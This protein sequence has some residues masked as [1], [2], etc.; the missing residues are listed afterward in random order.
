MLKK[1]LCLALS[2]LIATSANAQVVI[3]NASIG[4]MTVKSGI[5]NNTALVQEMLKYPG[6]TFVEDFS[7]GTIDADFSAGSPTGT[8]KST[9]SATA[10]A[11]YID[12]NGVIQVSTTSDVPLYD[13]GYYDATG[14][15]ATPMGYHAYRASTNLSEDSYT[16]GTLETY[17]AK[18]EGTDGTATIESSTERTN[19]YL[20]GQV[21]KFKGTITND[22]MYSAIG[23]RPSLTSGNVYTYSVMMRGSG[24]VALRFTIT[25]GTDFASSEITLTDTWCRYSATF[26]AN[27]TGVVAHGIKLLSNNSVTCYATNFQIEALPYA[28]PFIPTTTAALTRA[29]D[30]LKYENA[31]NST[32][33]EE[34][35]IV[36]FTPGSTFANDG[37][38][39]RM[40][41]S[42]TKNRRI[43]KDT[44]VT[45]TSFMPNFTDNIAVVKTTTTQNLVNTSYVVAGV[46]KHSS[47]YIE[48]YTNGSSQGTYTDGDWTNPAW[49]TYFGVGANIVAGANDSQLNGNIRRVIKFNRALSVDENLAIAQYLAA[50]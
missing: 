16:S 33:N 27:A 20:G 46:F 43:G 44:T 2:L 5:H 41:S 25:G 47:P 22:R 23:H 26:T 32:A 39:R 38:A 28:T 19:P 12:A 7:T 21:I 35:I 17:W 29:G 40:H 11:T 37:L 6:L 13:Y 24:K 50:N 18:A 42:E 3:G 10:P 4:N 31:G 9:R 14:F 34:T 48:V 1:F 15:H 36:Q 8:F 30:V 49:G 45:G